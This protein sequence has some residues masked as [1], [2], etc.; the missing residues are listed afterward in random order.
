MNANKTIDTSINHQ[1][2]IPQKQNSRKS[3]YKSWAWMQ[4]TQMPACHVQ[5]PEF[6]SQNPKKLKNKNVKLCLTHICTRRLML[7]EASSI[8]RELVKNADS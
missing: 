1:M 8:T 4:V 7:T 6:D 5:G 3:L 2:H